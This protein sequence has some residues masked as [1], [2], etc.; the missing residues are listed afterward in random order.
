MTEHTFE[1]EHG[2][3]QQLTPESMRK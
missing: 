2:K 1:C 3:A